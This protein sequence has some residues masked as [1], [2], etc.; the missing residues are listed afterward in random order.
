MKTLDFGS[1]C[2]SLDIDN[3][4]IGSRIAPTATVNLI[5]LLSDEDP[6]LDARCV[7]VNGIIYIG[8][9]PYYNADESTPTK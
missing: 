9:I 4:A 7:I 1:A 5:D 3:I 2:I 8:S 6:L